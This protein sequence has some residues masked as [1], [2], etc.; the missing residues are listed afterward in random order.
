MRASRPGFNNLELWMTAKMEARDMTVEEV[1]EAAG[2]S[3][4]TIYAYWKDKQRPGLDSIIAI[5]K[6]FNCKLEEGLAQYTAVDM[7]RPKKA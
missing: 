5:C 2:L 4:A 3:K 7:G 1:A 6:V